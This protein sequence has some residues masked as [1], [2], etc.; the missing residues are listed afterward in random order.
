MVANEI[1]WCFAYLFKDRKRQWFDDFY[2]EFYCLV[3]YIFI[4][5]LR[6]L[7]LYEIT[8]N[9]IRCLVSCS[10]I[11]ELVT[12]IPLN[13]FGRGN[14]LIYKQNDRFESYIYIYIYILN[15]EN[16]YFA[17]Y[18]TCIGIPSCVTDKTYCF[19]LFTK[20]T[21]KQCWVALQPIQCYNFQSKVAQH[22]QYTKIYFMTNR[23]ND[24]YILT[25]LVV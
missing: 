6:T 1:N 8:C 3:P 24:S 14:S 21:V 16:V 22:E 10:S 20:E 5:N 7:I 9:L 13:I 25:E 17:E 18:R 11:P 12:K 4:L 23:S 19:V 15:W 2:K